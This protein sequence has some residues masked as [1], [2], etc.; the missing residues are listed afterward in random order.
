MLANLASLRDAR[1]LKLRPDQV[2]NAQYYLHH[3]LEPDED[4]NARW[5][6]G[7]WKTLIPKHGEEVARAFRDGAVGFWRRN[8]PK[9]RSEGAKANTT[10]FSTIFGLGGLQ[11]EA[12]ETEGWPGNLTEAEAELAT[13]YAT[14]EL[15]GFPEWFGK[16]Y[17]HFPDAVTRV[18]LGEVR[19]ELAKLSP[20]SE[21]LGILYDVS[22]YGEAMWER[23]A[24]ILLQELTRSEPKS[25]RALSQMLKVIQ[26]SSLPAEQIRDLARKK[27]KLEGPLDH[28]AHWYAAWV[29]VDPDHGIPALE[30]RLVAVADDKARAT[31][32]ME[33]LTHLLGGRR[34]ES[35]NA[36]NAYRTA[37]HLKALYLLM[38]EHIRSRDDIERAG[39]GVYSPGLRDNAQEARNHLSSLLQEIPGKEAFVALMEISKAHPEKNS[40]PWFAMKAKSKAEQDVET[41]PWSVAQFVEF[42]AEMERTPANHRELFELA[43]LRMLDLKDDLERGD[44]SIATTLQKITLEPEMRKNIGNWLRDRAKGRYTVP[45][46]EELADATKPDVRFQGGSF[47]GPVPM[48]LKLADNNWSG[49]H[50]IERLENQLCGDYLRDNRSSRGIFCLVWRGEKKRWALPNSK[51]RVDFDGLVVALQAHWYAISDRFPGIEEVRVIGIDLT[52]RAKKPQA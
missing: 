16:L 13:R 17:D 14:Y 19:W 42:N 33:F 1:L 11:I 15:N 45:Q 2:S 18:L 20:E 39:K 49:A 4:N 50:L 7:N 52:K 23:W 24:P 46:E 29:G 36:R 31:F 6:G 21:G 32:A 44:S 43:W 51:K 47:D 37:S 40:R 28:L 5:R 27:C 34:G 30:E 25:I 12:S 10:L 8:K 41:G 9:L 35:A 22:W 3:R 48:E 26:G 38:N